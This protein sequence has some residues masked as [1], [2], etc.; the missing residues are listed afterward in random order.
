[1]GTHFALLR[2]QGHLTAESVEMH[3]LVP[4]SIEQ[5]L[6]THTSDVAEEAVTE[7]SKQT[8]PA[9]ATQPTKNIVTND[10]IT[11]FPFHKE[12]ENETTK[13][14]E[15]PAQHRLHRPRP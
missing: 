12:S 5:P 11:I 14:P 3:G 9:Q 2:L 13:V 7:R 8:R 15:Q 1:M 10:L 4:A 6:S